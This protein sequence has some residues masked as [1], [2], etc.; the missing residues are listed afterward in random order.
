[1]TLDEALR[2]AREELSRR[3]VED[4]ALEAE[5][6]LRHVL[7]LSRSQLYLEVERQITQNE[8]DK[9]RG[10]I[11][12]RLQ[13]EPTAYITGHREFYGLD[14]LV[15]RRVLIPRPESE[16]LVDTAI[17]LG[18]EGA[19]TFADIGTGSGC[20]AISVAAN[21]P[22]A[23]VYAT[24]VS[25]DALEVA[26]ANGLKHGLER[27]IRLLRGDLAEPLP[28]RVDVLVANLPYVRRAEVAVVNTRG[29]EPTLALDGGEDGLDQIRKLLGQSVSKVRAGG[30]ILL[31]IGAGQREAAVEAVMKTFPGASVRVLSDLGGIPRVLVIGRNRLDSP[32]P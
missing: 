29:Y 10:V 6:L 11:A 20:I 21:V 14:F 16:L 19:R 22:Q 7:G 30:S 9:L 17:E 24:D 27:R 8:Q 23:M 32:S 12:R 31:E 13:G 15:D 18:R 1:M 5:V 3:R 25:A 4:A 28:E 26:L 2:E